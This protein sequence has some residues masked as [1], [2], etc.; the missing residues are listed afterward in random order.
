[1][2]EQDDAGTQDMSWCGVGSWT[3]AE[4][5]GDVNGWIWNGRQHDLHNVLQDM[6]RIIWERA[7]DRLLP[8]E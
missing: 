6:F 4:D 1:M 5:I 3:Q 8:F 7:H 2:V